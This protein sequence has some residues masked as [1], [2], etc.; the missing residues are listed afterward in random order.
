MFSVGIYVCFLLGF[1]EGLCAGIDGFNV[2]VL[3]EISDSVHGL[4]LLQHVWCTFAT[5]LCVLQR[6]EL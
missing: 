4:G 1:A 2:C 3:L 6:S 5:E